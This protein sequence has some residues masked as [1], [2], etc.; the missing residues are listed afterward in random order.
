MNGLLGNWNNKFHIGTKNWHMNFDKYNQELFILANSW[1]GNYFVTTGPGGFMGTRSI[2]AFLLGFTLYSNKT[3]YGFNLLLDILP[4]IYPSNIDKKHKKIIYIY[5]DLNRFFYAVDEDNLKTRKFNLLSPNEVEL[6]LLDA[7]DYHLVGN[8][9]KCHVI[10]PLDFY[11]I[12]KTI[13]FLY[14]KDKEKYLF[15]KID[16]CNW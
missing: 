5:Q 4:V 14:S 10:I 15:N 8:W 7:H 16:Y 3:L 2:I 12:L 11:T 9:D 13:E 1:N 6:L